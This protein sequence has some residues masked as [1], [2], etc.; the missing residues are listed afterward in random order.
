VGKLKEERKEVGRRERRMYIFI[1]I[2]DNKN[3]R[4]ST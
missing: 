2:H 3:Y 1:E 4:T